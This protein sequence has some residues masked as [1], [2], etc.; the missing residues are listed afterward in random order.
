MA[1]S[2]SST[3]AIVRTFINSGVPPVRAKHWS[4]VIVR[5]ILT[6]P[7]NAALAVTAAGEI[8]E[9]TEHPAIVSRED[10]E[11]VVALLTNSTQTLGRK[12]QHLGSGGVAR[13]GTCGA[14]LRYSSQKGGIY[15][16]TAANNGLLAA[17]GGPHASAK[18]ADVDAQIITEIVPALMARLRRGDGSP[19][20]SD[21][22]VRAMLLRRAELERQRDDAQDLYILP[23][24]NKARV[25]VTLASIAEQIEGVEAQIAEARG[26]GSAAVIAIAA[27]LEDGTAPS[28]AAMGARF[29][30]VWAAMSLE[31][32]RALARALLDTRIHPAS[33]ARK[34]RI[35]TRPDGT[36]EVVVVRDGPERVAV[37]RI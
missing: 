11:A 2:G 9:L 25:R 20:S 6:R 3:Y 5:K 10:H 13:C 29:T 30:G 28:G 26:A 21:A 23:G 22:T 24:V 31:D 32:Q 19:A 33:V 35:E 12:P 37:R 34:T 14:P 16:C 27:A 1:L 18:A 17:D 7:R 4:Y 15:R 8:Y 36:S